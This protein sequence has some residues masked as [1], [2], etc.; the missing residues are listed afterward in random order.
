MLLRVANQVRSMLF[1]FISRGPISPR[2]LVA[3]VLP[4]FLLGLLLRAT[5]V[6]VLPDGYFGSDSASYYD[7]CAEF[8]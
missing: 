8:I 1:N 7:F 3:L 4:A 2:Q 6:L 5:F